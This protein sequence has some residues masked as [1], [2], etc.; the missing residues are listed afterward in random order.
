MILDLVK[1]TVNTNHCIKVTRFKWWF[2]NVFISVT[3]CPLTGN[4]YQ[5]E[6]LYAKGTPTDHSRFWRCNNKQHSIRAKASSTVPSLTKD[7]LQQDQPISVIISWL[8]WPSHYF[9]HFERLPLEWRSLVAWFHRLW[10]LDWAFDSSVWALITLS[11]FWTPTVCQYWS[12]DLLWETKQV[13]AP[14]LGCLWSTIR[15]SKGR[16]HS[17]W[18]GNQKPLCASNQ[19]ASLTATPF[20]VVR[21]ESPH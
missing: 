11:K 20:T 4:I 21:K 5:T 19:D 13:R 16:L 12:W 18:V 1:L 2:W 3:V 10:L 9:R 8:L 17:N 7:R 14:L 6:W 15:N